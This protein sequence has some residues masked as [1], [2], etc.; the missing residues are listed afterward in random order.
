[1]L[2]SQ[3]SSLHFLCGAKVVLLRDLKVE[4][5]MTSL[6]WCQK[7]VSLEL[8]GVL[9]DLLEAFALEIC[10]VVLA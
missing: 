10:I 8:F 5:H 9:K 2:P 6:S 4:L 3:C 7:R 1:M